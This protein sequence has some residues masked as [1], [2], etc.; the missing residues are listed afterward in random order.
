MSALTDLQARFQALN[1]RERGIV[2]GGGCVVVLALLYFLLL[3]PFYSAIEARSRRVNAKQADLAWLQ[4]SLAE[5]QSLASSQPQAAGPT[6]ESL[7]VVI[8]RTA[9]EASLGASLTGQT[10]SGDSGIRVRLENASFDAVVQWLAVLQQQ[11]G[12]AI[13]SAT[14]DRTA[15]AG[16]VNATLTLQRAAGG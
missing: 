8:D 5:V 13:E 2:I 10:P 1:P 14:I 16:V 4:G 9:R 12:V 6:G 7:V 15:A 11:Y 3:A